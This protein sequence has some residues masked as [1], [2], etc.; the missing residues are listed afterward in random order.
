MCANKLMRS[1]WSKFINYLVT[2]L[3]VLKLKLRQVLRSHRVADLGG[4]ICIGS[5]FDFL[6]NLH[7]FPL[8][9]NYSVYVNQCFVQWYG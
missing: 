1:K 3:T 5:I 9:H 2:I 4:H 7:Y 8:R 6:H